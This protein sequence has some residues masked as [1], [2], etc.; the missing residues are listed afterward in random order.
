MQPRHL[1]PPA[2]RHAHIEGRRRA[3]PPSHRSR[4][5][6]RGGPTRAKPERGGGRFPEALRRRQSAAVDGR[7][8]PSATSC[9]SPSR[10]AQ[11]PPTPTPPRHSAS[12]SGGEGGARAA[13]FIEGWAGSAG[14]S[15]TPHPDGASAPS[16]PLPPGE[17]GAR[18]IPRAFPGEGLR[19]VKE[20]GEQDARDRLS[21]F[22]GC[23]LTWRP[24]RRSLG[25]QGLPHFLRLSGVRPIAPGP[26]GLSPG[27]AETCGRVPE[28]RP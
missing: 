13:T 5:E 23:Q 25:S 2:E 26:D 4:S 6:W 18:R 20:R 3:P 19:T 27:P 9:S 22:I 28:R 10:L 12:P 24:A 7:P 17:V 15:M 14:N 11:P 1:S 16:R 8:G 21:I